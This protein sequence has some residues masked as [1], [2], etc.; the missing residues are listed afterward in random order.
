MHEKSQLWYRNLRRSREFKFFSSSVIHLIILLVVPP[1]FLDNDE[2]YCFYQSQ[3][4]VTSS[5]PRQLNCTTFSI[6]ESEVI[7]L[8]L[9]IRR[10]QLKCDGTR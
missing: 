7:I 2:F 3:L 5:F 9:F 8:Q 10:V 4:R 1:T 6:N